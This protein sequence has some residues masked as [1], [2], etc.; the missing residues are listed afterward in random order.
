L[1]LGLTVSND[2]NFYITHI[3]KY[4]G[5]IFNITENKSHH[6]SGI[7]QVVAVSNAG[8]AVGDILGDAQD[9]YWKG[10]L[11]KYNS[12]NIDYRVLDVPNQYL[13]LSGISAS[14]RFM[15]GIL[16]NLLISVN[17]LYEVELVKGIPAVINSVSS[18][19]ITVM[20]NGDFIFAGYHD[21]LSYYYYYS[22]SKA[23]V[24]DM[25]EFFEKIGVSNI[26][27]KL[28]LNELHEL[29]MYVAK[30]GKYMM[31]V[32]YDELGLIKIDSAIRIYFKNSSL[33]DYMEQNCKTLN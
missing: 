13:S 29:K 16:D 23:S 32:A 3:N 31:I 15:Y 4:A 28:H 8:I 11:F 14:G 5:D 30:D 6:I 26:I 21:Q 20:D 24:Y 25:G 18:Q 1:L 9:R 19:D 22:R 12:D 2:G 10:I 27:Q 17:N 33:Q 7:D